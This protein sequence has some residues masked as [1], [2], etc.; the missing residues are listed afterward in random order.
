MVQ[1]VNSRTHRNDE[2]LRFS[3]EEDREDKVAHFLPTLSNQERALGRV[4]RL[5]KELREWRRYRQVTQARGGVQMTLGRTSCRPVEYTVW[6]PLSLRRV[7]RRHGKH[8]TIKRVTHRAGHARRVSWI[9]GGVGGGAPWPRRSVPAP[10]VATVVQTQGHG[11]RFHI[12]THANKD[13]W[14]EMGGGRQ[15]QDARD[16]KSDMTP[17]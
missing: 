13:T 7:H 5:R 15:A 14:G 2:V 12:C 16:C 4:A 9:G 6:P 1:R 3:L 11:P 17:T 8:R 10:R